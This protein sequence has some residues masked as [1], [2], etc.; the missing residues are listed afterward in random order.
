MM[1]RPNAA[2][3]VMAAC[4]LAHASQLVAQ[5]QNTKTS[6][7][8]DAD[9]NV[10]LVTDGLNH[11]TEN[12]YDSLSRVYRSQIDGNATFFEYDGQNQLTKVTDGRG[13]NT[14]YAIDGLGNLKQTTSGDSGVTTNTYDEAG[15][16]L[17]RTDAKLQKTSY[18]YD[19]LSRPT[20]VTFS[21]GATVVY[22][23]DQGQNGIGRLGK[24]S[25]SSGSIAYGYDGRGRLT[26][27]TRTIGGVAYVT[28]YR[29]DNGGRLSS[30]TY[31][32]GLTVEYVPDAMGRVAQVNTVIGSSSSV[33]V[34][35]V[36]YQ[37]FGPVRSITFGNGQ[38]QVRGYD[39][40]GRVASYTQS[41][42]TVALGYNAANNITSIGD[43][44][45]L[46]GRTTYGYDYQDRLTSVATPTATQSYSYDAIGN[47]VVKWNNSSSTTLSYGGTGSRL[48]A[49]GNQAIVSDANG[50]ITSKG[51]ATFNYD[52]RG[53]MVSANT[54]IGL[55]QYLIN[56]LGQRVRKTT[57]TEMTVFHYDAAGKLIAE[58]TSSG[59]TSATQEYIYLGDMQVAVLK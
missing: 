25:D 21:D 45:D 2:N 33:V 48:T 53:R 49:I 29:Y 9:G 51:T 38:T 6:Y 46:P 12:R 14:V 35:A 56:S 37:P 50:S 40:D 10:T 57:P 31:P 27:E 52:A 22:E 59:S 42:K 8:Y 41:T 36:T 20:L 55:V 23:Y 30:M 18:Q 24:I 26:L 19:V 4:L 43:A 11:V 3:I 17:T 39:L 44:A 5:T 58:T 47:R 28:S 34:S 7:N 1:R 15:N 32:T 16:L 54:Q 13:R